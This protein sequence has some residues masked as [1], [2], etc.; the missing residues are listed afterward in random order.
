MALV[1]T[2]MAAAAFTFT[3]ADA[4]AAGYFNSTSKYD[5]EG[6]A[7]NPGLPGYSGWLHFWRDDGVFLGAL[8]AGIPRESAVGEICGDSGV[9]GFSGKL[10]VKYEHLDNKVHTVR[11]YFINPDNTNFELQNSVSVLFD[12]GPT[13]PPP[14]PPPVQPLVVQGCNISSPGVGWVATHYKT[15]YGCSPAQHPFSGH[16]AAWQYVGPDSP[17]VYS[18]GHQLTICT[19]TAPAG[20]YRAG[21]VSS[22]S[23][24]K[25]F[26]GYVDNAYQIIKY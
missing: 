20:W 18:S 3:V 14:P 8:H 23:C 10:D 22:S 9:H 1:R 21:V 6:W 26:Y 24:N 15:D 4:S 25:N 11:A 19:S 5:Y 2:L 17:Y 12:G 7:C 13:P 16:S